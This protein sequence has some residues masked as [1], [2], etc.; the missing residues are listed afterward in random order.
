MLNV[1]ITSRALCFAATSLA[2]ACGAI[3]EENDAPVGKGIGA[4]G[5]F[6]TSADGAFSVVFPPGALVENTL[7][8][9][10]PSADA[11]ASLGLSYN[12]SGP[13]GLASPIFLEYRYTLPQLGDRAPE[14]INLAAAGADRWDALDDVMVDPNLQTVTASTPSLALAFGLI[15]GAGGSV[16]TDGTDA[17]GSSGGTDTDDATETDADT[18]GTDSDPTDPVDT[19]D[20]SDTDAPTGATGCG[21][22]SA[23]PGELCWSLAP[24]PLLGKG[25]GPVALAAGDLDGAPGDDIVVALSGSTSVGVWLSD[26]VGSFGAETL[27]AISAAPTALTLADLNGDGTIDVAAASASAVG[28]LPGDGA[29]TL[30]AEVANVVAGGSSALAVG[31]A[32]EDDFSDLFVAHAGPGSVGML[33]G[34]AMG[35]M[36]EVTTPVGAGPLALSLGD[37]TGDDNLDLITVG[38]AGITV[39]SGNGAGLF[40][41]PL[42]TPV[43]G[44]MAGLATGDFN[45]DGRLDAAVIDSAGSRLV[46]FLGDGLGGF[47]G[48]IPYAVGLTPAALQAG[49]VDGDGAL[50]LVVT[51]SGDDSVTVLRGQGNG[52][53]DADAPYTVGAAPGALALGDFNAD[54]QLDA[55][56][57]QTTDGSLG[58]LLSQP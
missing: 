47:G 54:G 21:D 26:G 58:L 19:D 34:S 16:D 55:V 32:N 52:G 57:V 56:V 41:K 15:E 1:R 45:A 5:G 49:D 30:G 12:I 43:G 36:M 13:A 33:A 3:D 7:V 28:L 14:D 22:G 48:A 11:P 20:P 27:Y 50:D 46:V 35:L 6:V 18:D 25:L 8:T 2:L 23:D 37:A 24:M 44:T 4:A 40:G 29:G 42:T 51:G 17:D 53:F 31:D 10:A 9:V 39:V 38:T